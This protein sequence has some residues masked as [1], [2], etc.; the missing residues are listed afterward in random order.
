MPGESMRKT[1]GVAFSVSLVCS[2]LVTTTVVSMQAM[3]EEN[4]RNNR[5]DRILRDLAILRP[6]ESLEA[7]EKRIR[8]FLV[9]LEK[10]EPLPEDRHTGVLNTDTYDI[11]TMAHSPEYGRDIRSERDLA[12]LGRIPRYMVVYRVRENGAADRHVF[13]IYGKGAWSTLYGVI[14]L[15]RDLKTIEGITFYEHGETP[16][17]GGEVDSPRW[18]ARW[19]GKR[20]FDEKGDLRI[21]VIRGEVDPSSEDARYRIDGISGATAT[22]RAVDQLVRFWLGDEGYGPFIKK[23]RTEEADGSHEKN[24]VRPDPR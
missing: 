3:Q 2:V 14:A 10:G 1:I 23:L 20:A 22:T 18:K 16:G 21:R 17:L 5:I 6:G 11:R 8:P 7:G 13:T 15:G 12:G 24:T 9:D 4:R 19:R